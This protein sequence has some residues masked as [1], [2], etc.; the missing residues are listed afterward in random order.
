MRKINNLLKP[1]LMKI[2]T[3]ILLSGLSNFLYSY[4]K[5]FSLIPCKIFLLS[6]STWSLC[7]IDPTLAEGT[8]YFGLTFLDS[9]YLNFFWPIVIFIGLFMLVIP[10]LFSCFIVEGYNYIMKT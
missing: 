2:G 9:L 7:P 6:D 4:M 10:Y 1:S 8:I 3:W 5:S